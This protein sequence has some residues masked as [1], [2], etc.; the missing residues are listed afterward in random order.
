[1]VA[2]PLN[3]Y[4]AK[5]SLWKGPGTRSKDYTLFDKWARE[6]INIG[7]VEVYVHLY[8][9][10]A[11]TAGTTTND[12]ANILNISDLVNME[13]R[14]RKYDPN[15]Y[16]LKCHYQMSDTEF[17]LKQFGLFLS[18]D[19]RFI[20]FH[21][22][23]M[24]KTLGRRLMSGD[25][26]EILIRDLAPLNGQPINQFY[27]VQDGTW[28]AEG[29]SHTWWSHL[30]RVKCTPMANSQEFSDILNQVLQDRG[31]GVPAGATNPDGSP[32]TVGDLTSTY[33]A[34]LAVNDAVLAEAMA[35][36]RFRNYQTAHFYT[37][38]SDLNAPIDV[39]SGDGIPPNDS[40]PVPSGTSFPTVYSVGDYFLRIDYVP[41]VLYQRQTNA[42][43]LVET[44]YRSD[45]LPAGRVLASFINNTDKTV[46]TDGTEAPVK[47]N[48]RTAIK[49]K[50]DPDII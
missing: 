46:Y 42:W 37:Q 3:I 38:Q 8:V 23:D 43:V 26:I 16:S 33:N 35:N 45:W 30:W 48:L 47:Q 25:V 41:P 21:Q 17:D 1:M 18:S 14:N 12:A 13:I 11:E 4:M 39:F 34:E 10:P 19:T 7:G 5:L 32:A 44:N 9:G 15:V 50:P 36:V 28:P 24:I 49:A 40:K 29:Y 2:P 31:D 27:V 20:T 6:Q 22:N